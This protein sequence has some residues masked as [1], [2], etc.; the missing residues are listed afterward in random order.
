MSKQTA[1]SLFKVSPFGIRQAGFYQEL[2]RGISSYEQL[3]DRLIQLAEQARQSRRPR[4][5]RKTVD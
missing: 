4:P 2:I 1:N 3:G 5:V